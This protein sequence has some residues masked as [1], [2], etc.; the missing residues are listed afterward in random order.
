MAFTHIVSTADGD[1][2]GTVTTDAVD[3]TGATLIVVSV[4]WYNPGGTP[5]VSDSEGNTWTGLTAV[6]AGDY[7]VRLYYCV[8]PTTDAAHTFTAAQAGT[9][10]VIGVAAFSGVDTG[11]PLDQESAG[12]T[13]A[14][15]ASLQPGSVTPDE[16]D[17]LVVTA[18]ATDPGNTHTINGGYAEVSVDQSGGNNIGGAIGYLIQTSAAATNPT[19]SWTAPSHARA[20]AAVFHAGAGGGGGEEPQYLA[21]NVSVFSRRVRHRHRPGG[22]R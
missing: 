3:T 17:C 9:F 7:R 6:G 1:S 19:W 10:P 15:G 2:S 16:D 18:L 5:A 4:S 11:D 22:G 13:V 12:G 14:G 20:A 21:G 8:S